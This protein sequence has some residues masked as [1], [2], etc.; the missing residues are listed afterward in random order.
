LPTKRRRRR[1]VVTS[2][3]RSIA[4]STTPTGRAIV[5]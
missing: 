4:K 3:Q 1:S 5:F 2:G